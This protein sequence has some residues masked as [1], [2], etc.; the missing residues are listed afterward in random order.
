M[1]GQI[2][3]CF[4]LISCVG[5]CTWRSFLRTRASGSR[6]PRSTGLSMRKSKRWWECYSAQDLVFFFLL[7]LL[8]HY[9]V[10]SPLISK[11]TVP[12]KWLKWFCNQFS[13]FNVRHC[14]IARLTPPWVMSLE[15]I[16]IHLHSVFS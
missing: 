15:V 1:E 16:F 5:S 14:H 10:F 2:S 6:G 3:A 9:I 8:Y 4:N 7:L 13:T 11:Y 12:C